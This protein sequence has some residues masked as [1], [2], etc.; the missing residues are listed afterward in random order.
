MY[1]SVQEF[2]QYPQFRATELSVLVKALVQC[3]S[4]VA[5]ATRANGTM[6]SCNHGHQKEGAGTCVT[7]PRLLKMWT[8]HILFPTPIN[9]P[10]PHF[11]L[12]PNENR[13]HMFDS[14]P[15]NIAGLMESSSKMVETA[16]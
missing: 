12:I 7:C 10:P 9:P 15:Y 3:T 8:Y 5:L 14:I 1:I 6:E 13:R 2:H 16:I 11:F 4:I